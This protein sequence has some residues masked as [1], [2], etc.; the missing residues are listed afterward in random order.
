VHGKISP[1]ES[2]TDFEEHVKSSNWFNN[3][4]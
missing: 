4:I 3:N 1:K 2:T